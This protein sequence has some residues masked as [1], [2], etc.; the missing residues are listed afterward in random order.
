[1]T[2]PPPA[3]ALTPPTGQWGHPSPLSRLFSIEMWERFGYYGMRALLTLYLTKHFVLGDRAATGLYGGY[4]ALVYLTP[5]VGG[6]VA[7]QL[8]GAKR[9]VRLGAGLMAAGY[10]ALAFGGAPSASYVAWDAQRHPITIAHF[11]DGPTSASGEQR[12]VADGRQMLALSGNA[13]GSITLRA[14][15]GH[16]ARTLS[17]GSF[18][19]GAEQ[20]PVAMAVLLLALAM[21]CV[22]NGLFKPNI[23]T[24]VG[25]L[26]GANDRRRDAGF[27]IFYMGINLGSILGQLLC[28][29]FADWI[30]WWAGFG[31]AGVGMTIA[32]VLITWDGGR[33]A[34]LGEAPA[35]GGPA[36]TIRVYAGAMLA[37][38]L[39]WWLLHNLMASPE[40][41]PGSGLVGYLAA[42]PLMGRLLFGTF[43]LGV[44]TILL[45]ARASASAAEFQM[46]LAAMVLI[47]FNSVFW[48]LFEQA[49]SSLTLFA[50]RNTNRSVFGLFTM[51][52]PQ[53]QNFNPVAIVLLAP[54]GTVDPGEIR[55]GAG[56]RGRGIPAAGAGC[57]SCRGRCQG[58]AVVAGGAVCRPLHRRVVHLAGGAVDDHQAV[59]RPHYGADDGGVVPVNLGGAICRGCPGAGGQRGDGGRRGH[60]SAPQP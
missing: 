1:M 52:A 36:P 6:L 19:E 44:P 5:L 12:Q 2:A 31:V 41:A 45:W 15:D 37:V 4:T 39:L 40:A 43:A 34:G 50:D 26:Y 25:S 28:P 35:N 13:D 53:T 48:T 57:R 3:P 46:M 23:S 16:V 60:Q 42:L 54:G 51:S 56:G 18:H 22:G 59:H 9:S 47:T 29:I 17:P 49:G 58:R 11:H 27:T 55:A 14:A 10:F 20:S 8:F 24:M 21:L 33:L 7:D 30:G 32:F 38:P